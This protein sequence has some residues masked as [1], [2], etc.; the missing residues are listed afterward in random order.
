MGLGKEKNRVNI[1][2]IRVVLSTALGVEKV[3]PKKIMPE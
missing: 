3:R 1:D 2:M